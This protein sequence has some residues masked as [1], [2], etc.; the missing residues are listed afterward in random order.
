MQSESVTGDAVVGRK[1]G[2]K[3]CETGRIRE[4]Q[5]RN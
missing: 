5:L 4:V 3:A 2:R 1:V